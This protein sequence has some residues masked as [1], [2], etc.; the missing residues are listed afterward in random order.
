MCLLDMVNLPKQDKRFLP[1]FEMG[2]SGG[3]DE[4]DRAG[5]VFLKYSSAYFFLRHG[6]FVI[7]M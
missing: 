6:D 7:C 3:F 4:Y 1:K 2:G 5:G